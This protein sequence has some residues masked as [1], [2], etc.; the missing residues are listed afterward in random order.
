M[1]A[2]TIA[3]IATPPGQGGVAIIRV[4]GPN[5]MAIVNAR[6][7]GTQVVRPRHVYVGRLLAARGGPPIDQVLVFSMPGPGSYTGEDVVEIQCHGGSVVSRRILES[8]LTAGARA[9]EPGEFTKRA[10]LNGRIDLAQA[11]AVADLIAAKSDAAARLAWSQLEGQLST[12][13]ETLRHAIIDARACCEAAIDFPDEDLPEISDG[14][15]RDELARVRAE[16]TRLVATFERARVRYEGARLALVGKPNVGKSSLLNLLVGRERAIVTPVPGTTRDVVEAAL[17]IAGIPV[18]IA[19]TAGI[20]ASDDAVERLGVER[21]RAAIEDAAIV[22]AVFDRARALDAE[23]TMVA[24]ATRG[25]SRIAVLNKADL[26]AVVTA[27]MVSDLL[28]GAPVVAMSALSGLGV[29]A[30]S[31]AVAAA[32]IGADEGEPEI[33]MYRARHRDAASRAVE[34]L[35]R[36]ESALAAGAPPELIASDLDAAATA[37]AAITGGVT[38]EDVLDRVF[39]EFCIGK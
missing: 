27:E 29:D 37:L 6:L 24:A 2:D 25:R 15:L 14:R 34:D 16:L 20:R 13:V 18:I 33:A 22:L 3:A 1:A 8:V 19:D 17:A 39:A 23:D 28:P 26:P 9:A 30:L 4:S 10:F 7:G 38:S 12:R 21:S 11:E 32:L 36:A 31:A 5:A 35:A